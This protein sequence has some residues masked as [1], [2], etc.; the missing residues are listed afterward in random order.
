MHFLGKDTFHLMEILF[1]MQCSLVQHI[2]MPAVFGNGM[3][4]RSN[5][6]KS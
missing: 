3:G 2:H 4:S 6:V 1:V 5:T